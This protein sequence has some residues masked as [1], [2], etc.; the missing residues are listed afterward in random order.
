MRA[1]ETQCAV[2]NLKPGRLLEAAHI[3]PDADAVGDPVVT[4][5]PSLCTIHHAAYDASLLGVS[6]D[7]VVGI[8]REL[9]AAVDGPMLLHGLPEMHGRALTVPQ[10]R[11]EQPDRERLSARWEQFRLGV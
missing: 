3:T 10:R 8:D 11:A 7:D 4:N 6:P 9:L 2:C 5:G 1:Y